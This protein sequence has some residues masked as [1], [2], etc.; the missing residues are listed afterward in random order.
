METTPNIGR[1]IQVIGNSCS[2]KS[3]LG[4]ELANRLSVPFVELDALNWLPG[5]VALNDT[6]P[7][8]LEDRIREATE[9]GAWV[10][11]GSYRGFCERIF[12]ERLEILIWL[13]LP[14]RTLVRRVLVRSWR[15]WRSQEL[16]WGTNT[17]CFWPH[18]KFW[19]TEDSLL[20]F[21]VAMHRRK[22]RRMLETAADPRWN[23][24]RII[25]LRSQ[26]EVSEFL[27]QEFL[28]GRVE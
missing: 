24:I 15:R 28:A 9:G 18:L 25:R 16:L 7:D 13:D 22:R 3:T 14:M 19:N 8:Q 20:A 26:A 6:D 27:Q 1:R 2:G 10:V 21:I 23:H 5:W 12:W 4:E 17:E 11:A